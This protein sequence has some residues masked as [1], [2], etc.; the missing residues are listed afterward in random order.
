MV[1]QYPHTITVTGP[2]AS[3]KDGAGNWTNT[4]SA[5]VTLPCR[6]EPAGPRG[7]IQGPDGTLINAS[8]IVYLPL[9]V[10][11]V[12]LDATVTINDGAVL[13]AKDKV[14]RFYKGQLN[15]RVWL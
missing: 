13:L 12:P 8:W 11:P 7:L 4:A 10:N 14:L 9:P 1:S 3:V 5:T 6:A 15:A 2:T